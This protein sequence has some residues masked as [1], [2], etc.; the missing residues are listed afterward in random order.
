M[1]LAAAR[2]PAGIP[3]HHP[4]GWSGVVT[5]P[6]HG[7][8]SKVATN[9]LHLPDG[10]EPVPASHASHL[11]EA[12]RNVPVVHVSYLL[13][14]EVRAGWFAPHVLQLDGEGP[15]P[16][17]VPVPVVAPVRVRDKRTGRVRD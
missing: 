3:V 1:Q 5:P 16:V 4:A 14:G 6:T 11:G 8:R 9:L 13:G 10:G 12:S 17:A 7:P 2:F 15:K